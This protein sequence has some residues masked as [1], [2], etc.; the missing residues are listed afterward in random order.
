M[1]FIRD[2]KVIKKVVIRVLKNLELGAGSLMFGGV[3]KLVELE[4][5]FRDIL[6]NFLELIFEN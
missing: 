4:F 1:A 3:L 2:I 5:S 6:V